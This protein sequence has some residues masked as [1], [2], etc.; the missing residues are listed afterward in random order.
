M[1]TRKAG[2]SC[3]SVKTLPAFDWRRI[4]Q[5]QGLYCLV[6][7][8]L[9]SFGCIFLLFS[10]F[11]MFSVTHDDLC[12]PNWLEFWPKS[13]WPE[14]VAAERRVRRDFHMVQLGELSSRRHALEGA[15][16]ASGDQKTLKALRDT[17]RRPAVPS[18]QYVPD[19]PF[20]L[21]QELFLKNVRTA[22][23]RAAPGPSGVT[24]DNLRPLLECS[25]VASAL[26]HAASLLAENRTPPE[27]MKK[28]NKRCQKIFKMKIVSKHE[29]TNLVE[30]FS[31]STTFTLSSVGLFPRQCGS[32]VHCNPF[33]IVHDCHTRRLPKFSTTD[34][35]IQRQ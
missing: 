34:H 2:M 13:V 1:E 19:E 10:C 35:H 4:H 28:K 5:K 26:S 12:G 30:K 17:S 15:S 24:V 8:L 22:R 21:S 16:L 32:S 18:A 14:S 20:S 7:P 3:V 33:A 9:S 25:A 11:P 31:I 6:P 29:T 27:V 23:R